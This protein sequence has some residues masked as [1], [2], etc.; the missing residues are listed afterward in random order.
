ML[1]LYRFSPLRGITLSF[2]PYPFAATEPMTK[3]HQDAA[4]SAFSSG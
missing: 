3:Y 2:K 4:D 1:L